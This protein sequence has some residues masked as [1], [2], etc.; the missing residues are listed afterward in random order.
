METG[1]ESEYPPQSV[2]N[3]ITVC[4]RIIRKYKKFR[5]RSHWFPLFLNGSNRNVFVFDQTYD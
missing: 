3:L 5:F 4:R 1:I 2:F